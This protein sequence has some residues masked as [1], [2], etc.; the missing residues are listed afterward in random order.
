VTLVHAHFSNSIK[1][2]QKK[3]PC[4]VYIDGD[5]KLNI[6]G[7]LKANV[8]TFYQTLYQKD[9]ATPKVLNAQK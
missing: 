2:K 1:P 7:E 3:P 4:K 9:L 5:Q 8:T 6:Q